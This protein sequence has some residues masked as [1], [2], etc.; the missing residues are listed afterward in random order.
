[1]NKRYKQKEIKKCLQN[2]K[3]TLAGLIETRVKENNTR[4]TINNI[5]AGWNCLNNYKD[6][7]NGRIWI[8]WDDSWYEVKLITSATQ[9]IHCYIQERSKGFQFH[10]TVVYGF[11]TIE[12]RK[13][14]WSDMIQIGQNVNHPWI[15]V[16]DFNAM[17]SPK[18]RLAGVPVNEN[19]IKDFSNCVKVMGLNEV[20][21]KGN[22]YTWN[23]KQS[24]NKRISRRIDRAFGNE[25]WM[26]KWGH[27]ILEYGNPG[28]S[29]H[30]PMHLI[31]HQ[32]YQQEKGKDSMKMVWNKLKA[33]QH[34]LKQLNNR[35]FKYINKQIEEARNELAEVQNQLSNQAKDD[36]IGKEK[37]ILT[38][39]EKWSML[40]ENAL[41]QKARAMWIKLGDANNKYFS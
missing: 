11:N 2:N 32:T 16:G 15:I 10:L 27:V 26:D 36:L 23:N 25:D 13:S 28:V 24:G 34:V 22:Y 14:L 4:T 18:D 9:M 5:A 7:V 33:L 38:K 41:R 40:E 12:Q 20:Q 6:A 39:L 1:M 3:V 8:I 29:D 30:S 19:E 21:W 35:E 37:E 31:L 17:L